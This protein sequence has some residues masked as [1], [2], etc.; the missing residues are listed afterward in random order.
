MT[1]RRFLARRHKQLAQLQP[2]PQSRRRLRARAGPAP[3]RERTFRARE[4]CV[5]PHFQEGDAGA[6]RESQ[7]EIARFRK[8][9]EHFAD[10][11]GL[12]SVIEKLAVPGLPVTRWVE[13]MMADGLTTR[14]ANATSANDCQKFQEY[15]VVHISVNGLKCLSARLIGKQKGGAERP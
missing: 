5:L 13:E 8:T 6:F 7:L 11:G 4:V 2:P 1:D 15:A 12:R 9:H 14:Q 3:P 10:Q